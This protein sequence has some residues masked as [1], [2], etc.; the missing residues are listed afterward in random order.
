MTWCV[1]RKK[2][3]K[4]DFCLF[5]IITN[6][7]WQEERNRYKS[8]CLFFVRSMRSDFLSFFIAFVAG[9][10]FIGC[11]LTIYFWWK[12]AKQ[13]KQAIKQ[14]R[15]VILGEISEKMLPIFPEFLYHSKDLVFIGKGVDYIIF[16]GLAEGELRDI[17]FL[18]IK[19]GKSQLNKN[20]RMIQQFL[21]TKR[22]R[23]ELINIKY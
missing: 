6:F 11:I 15:S 14:S 12:I 2:T 16:D 10:A 23:Y 4:S 18:E 7:L 8:D 1:I 13:R 22:A 20:E 17:I 5:F 21:S 9:G 3:E 19:T